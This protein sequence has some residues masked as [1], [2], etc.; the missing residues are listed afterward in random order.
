MP[1]FRRGALLPGCLALI[2][3]VSCGIDNYLY[4]YPVT[5]IWVR[6]QAYASFVLP[7]DQADLE[8]YF[9]GYRIFY[10]IY[11]SNNSVAGVIGSS[12][13]AAV[14]PRLAGHHAVFASYFKAEDNAPNYIQSV[15]E[16]AGYHIL[17]YGEGERPL[18]GT[19]VH[20][21][22]AAVDFLYEPSAVLSIEGSIYRLKRSQGAS[23]LN[24][25]GE[26]LLKYSPDLA[27]SDVE[28]NAEGSAYAYAAL[29][30]LAQGRDDNGSL[31]YSAPNLI[32]VFE[33]K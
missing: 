15:F 28:P 27:G 9:T 31:A 10:R 32:G 5:N 19:A 21:K 14:N 22:T 24:P 4:L 17:E 8:D 6:D 11:A 33:L 7:S 30:I 18:T 2:L 13:Y 25:P 12:Q 16:N 26:Y 23:G 29:Y 20:G 1:L 3:A